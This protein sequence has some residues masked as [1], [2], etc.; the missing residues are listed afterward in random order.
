MAAPSPSSPAE[1]VRAEVGDIRAI[2]GL[3]GIAVLWVVAFHYLVLREGKFDDAFVAL[4][5]GL[6]PVHALVRNGYIGV[7]LFFLITGFL[8]TLPWFKHA[9]DAKPAPSAR[10]FYVRRIRRI[11]PAYY[12]QLAFLAAVC[13]PVLV[14]WRFVK[15]EL[16]FVLANLAAHASFLHYATPLTSASFSINGALWTLAI[17]FQYYL[18]LPLLAPLFVRRPFA[19]A[20]AFV[21]I[22][23]GWRWAA[24]H[25]FGAWVDL[26]AAMSARWQVPESAL[27]SLIATQLPGYLAH[28]AAGILCGRA[29]LLARPRPATRVRD[30]MLALVALACAAGLWAVLRFGLAPLGEFSWLVHPLLLGGAMAAAVSARPSWS[31]AVLATK[32]LAW[33]GRVSYS[34]YLYH[35]PLV[36]LMGKLLPGFGGWAALPAYL[37]ALMAVS[38]LSWRFVERPFLARRRA[39]S[40]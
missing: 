27:R 10:A 35:M 21:A 4:V 9:R 30:A 16:L 14:S 6:A 3:R 23:I 13:L 1:G 15:A 26:Y 37:A 31:D 8:L 18:L 19:A 38:W 12:V 25:S 22:A 11:V 7:D 2:E 40:P 36:L 17:E 29:W 32:P 28:F 20:A 5:N 33:V 34:T 39:D 24:A